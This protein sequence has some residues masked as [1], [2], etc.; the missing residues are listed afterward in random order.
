MATQ[1][2][3]RFF[4]FG[5]CKYTVKC[6]FLN[7]KENCENQECDV[8][9]CNLR[10]PRICSFFETTIGVNLVNGVASDMFI[11]LSKVIKK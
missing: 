7:V 5:F 10:H 6:R 3:C 9:S 1:N 11:K 8:I 2:V 4:K